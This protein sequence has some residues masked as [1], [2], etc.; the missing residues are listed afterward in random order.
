[1]RS[2]GRSVLMTTHYMEE[3]EQ[4]CDRLAIMDHGKLLEMGTVEEIVSRRFHERAVKFDQ[5]DALDDARLSALAGVTNVA[6]ED[7]SVLLYTGDVPATIGA[8]LSATD[9]LGL[10][11]AN[12]LVRRPSLED[13]FLALTG[14]ALRE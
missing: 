4:L 3:A 13:V 2:D 11:P 9:A 10:E 14:R 1:M 6:R 7:G 12:L 5:L 8:L